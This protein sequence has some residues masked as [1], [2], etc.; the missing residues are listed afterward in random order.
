MCKLEF[1][2]FRHALNPTVTET[3]QWSLPGHLWPFEWECRLDKL[4]TIKRRYSLCLFVISPNY[5][6]DMCTNGNMLI[7][8]NIQSVPFARW[9][10]MFLHVLDRIS[11]ANAS[12]KQRQ[13]PRLWIV[14]VSVCVMRQMRYAKWRI[15]VYTQWITRLQTSM[16]RY[17]QM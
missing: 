15:A 11:G 7:N 2:Y 17:N 3:K 9:V 13:R 14:C 4:N 16:L 10:S 5:P 8:Y 12:L 1:M 6:H